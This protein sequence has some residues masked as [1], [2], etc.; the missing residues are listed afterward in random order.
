M[1]GPLVCVSSPTF[2]HSLDAGSPH[3][4]EEYAPA[5]YAPPMPDTYEPPCIEE[6]TDIGPAIIGLIPIGSAN[7]D[8]APQ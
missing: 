7:I 5:G 6:R 3:I 4:D 8:G 2:F 1:G